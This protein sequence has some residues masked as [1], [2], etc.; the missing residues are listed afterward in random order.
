MEFTER[1]LVLKTGCFREADMWVRLLTPTKGLMTA[2]AFGGGKS[3]RRFC[4]CLDL[5]NLV[6]FRI[7]SGRAG[8]HVLEEGTLLDGFRDLKLDRRKLGSAANCVRFVEAL[9]LGPQDAG[10]GYELLVETLA[11][12]E[13]GRAAPEDAPFL[14]RARVAFDIGYR[15]DFRTCR[16]CGRQVQG[17]G[18]FLFVVDRGWVCCP[19]CRPREGVS[20][21]VSAGSLLTLDWIRNSRPGDWGR[22]SISPQIKGPCYELVDRFVGYHLGVQ[23]DNGYFRKV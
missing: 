18:R 7:G 6:L 13:S 15:P 11:A 19:E 20:L 3:R 2:F 22:L 10:V 14:F 17:D 5:L 4:G 8:Y 16:R 12:L 23:W 9:E 1:A 21:P